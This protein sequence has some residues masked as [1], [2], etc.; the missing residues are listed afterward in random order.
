MTEIDH[1]HGGLLQL[2]N[3][4][5]MKENCYSP[6]DVLRS[7]KGMSIGMSPRS[8]NAERDQKDSKCKCSQGYL[9]SVGFPISIFSYEEHP[10]NSKIA[11]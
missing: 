6:L 8:K 3:N 1:C 10:I 4:G 9:S 2:I 7:G 5:V 11:L